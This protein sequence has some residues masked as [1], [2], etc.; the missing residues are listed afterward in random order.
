MDYQPPPFFSRFERLADVVG[1]D[2][3]VADAGRRRW[4]FYRDHGYAMQHHRLDER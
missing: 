3:E 2:A 1:R 4:K